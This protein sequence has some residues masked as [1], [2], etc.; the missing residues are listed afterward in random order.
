MSDLKK[1]AKRIKI[2]MISIFMLAA[3]F[4]LCH[5]TLVND[6][7]HGNAGPPGHIVFNIEET[8][9]DSLT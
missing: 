9:S 1:T 8:E 4:F 2:L 6:A 3:V 7:F 5:Y